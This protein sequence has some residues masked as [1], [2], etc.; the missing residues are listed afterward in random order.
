MPAIR[1]P[2]SIADGCP[3]IQ[4]ATFDPRTA[5]FARSF[6]FE[7]TQGQTAGTEEQA[8]STGGTMSWQRPGWTR[9]GAPRA[10][11]PK[12][13]A[14]EQRCLLASD[15]VLDWNAV[16]LNAVRND[17]DLGH[18][19]DQAGPTA[20]SRALAIVHAAMFDAFNSIDG[21]FMP[22]L[23]VAPDARG[24]SIDAAVAQAAH[25]TRVSLY[26]QPAS[27]FDAALAS[28]LAHVHS[29][30]A[31]DKGIAVGQFVASASLAARADDGSDAPLDY[32]PIGAPGH[33]QPDP[34]HPD[35]GFL[36]PEW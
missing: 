21:R 4:R 30:R 23:T 20:T 3:G 15:V 33:H 28:S 32:H 2:I 18:T 26:P 7:L 1:R 17:Y 9:S 14:L 29:G 35:Q 25:D 24:A 19:P 11:K 6:D 27:M 5:I 8:L 12:V 16:A 13:E 31:E 10:A 36:G 22:Y 34:L